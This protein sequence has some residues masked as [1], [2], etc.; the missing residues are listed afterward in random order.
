M[1]VQSQEKNMRKLAGLLGRDLSYIWGERE[2]GPNGDKKVFLNTGKAFLRALAKDLGLREYKVS[3]NPGGIAV[4]GE[5]TL[6]GMWNN[7]GIYIMIG[8]SSFGFEELV[9]YRKVKHIKDYSGGSNRFLPRD[10]LKTMSYSR[11][12]NEFRTLRKEGERRMSGQPERCYAVEELKSLQSSIADLTQSMVIQRARVEKYKDTDLAAARALDT[13]LIA[14]IT[15][16]G[17]EYRTKQNGHQEKLTQFLVEQ[18]ADLVLGGHPH[19]L[20]PYDTVT[21]T[22]EDG[23]ERQGFVIYS[24]GNFISNQNFDDH[25]KDLATK[26]TVILDLELTKDPEGNTALTDVR[27]TPY[28]MV[29]RNNKPAGERRHW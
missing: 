27:Y 22:G 5:T 4:S 3:A 7:S 21:V 11:L 10:A 29:H 15:H 12:L 6:I 1:S 9:I 25:K 18:G 26:T 13:D 8:Q 2:S 19:V 23:Q 16:W 17:I 20:Q 28:Y 24:L 14:V